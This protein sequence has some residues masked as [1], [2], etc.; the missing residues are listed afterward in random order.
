MFNSCRPT[1]LPLGTLINSRTYIAQLVLFSEDELCG[2]FLIV[3]QSDS[4]FRLDPPLHQR[5]EGDII[6]IPQTTQTEPIQMIRWSSLKR[7]C[8]TSGVRLKN[9]GAWL[10]VKIPR[11]HWGAPGHLSWGLNHLVGQTWKILKHAI[12]L[13]VLE[14]P[15]MKFEVDLCSIC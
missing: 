7:W 12:L 6:K 3:P 10:V 4:C 14:A 9:E 13:L 11:C 5:E 1:P 8:P 2:K 15:K